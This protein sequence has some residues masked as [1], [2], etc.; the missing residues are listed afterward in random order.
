MKRVKLCILCTAIASVG[1]PA[2]AV[3]CGAETSSAATS[4]TGVG[5]TG[6]GGSG[7]ADVGA[8]ASSAS[9]S[10]ASASSTGTGLPDGGSTTASGGDAGVDC[11][12]FKAVAVDTN[13]L[14]T[15]WMGEVG[16]LKSVDC[17]I[18]R[19]LPG[20]LGNCHEITYS[21]AAG[22]DGWVGVNWQ[23]PSNY[24]TD[25]PEPFV[26]YPMPCGAVRIT[27]YARGK[28]GGEVVD[29]WGG[30]KAYAAQRAKVK[31]TTTWTKYIMGFNGDPD[32]NVTLGFGW[33]T[34][35]DSVGGVGAA[36]GFYIDN[37]LWE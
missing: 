20:A 26:G 17:T 10:S 37:I 24:W 28:M 5:S 16:G 12:S 36:G 18:A 1:A 29:F 21:P 11:S 8:S 31:L 3:G 22:G 13:F 34:G 15:G 33:S 4:T 6:V 2:W 35:A 9:A 27:F 30:N 14:P 25:P 23:N 19:A 32:D 7:G